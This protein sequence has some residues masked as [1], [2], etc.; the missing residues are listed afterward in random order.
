MAGTGRGR[1]VKGWHALYISIA[2]HGDGGVKWCRG[3]KV[4]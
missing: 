2:L 1:K 4:K 3:L